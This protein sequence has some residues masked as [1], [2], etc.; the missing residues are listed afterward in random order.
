ML[1]E[2][3]D[4]LI[5]LRTMHD[6]ISVR[7][8]TIENYLRKATT[9]V[10]TTADPTPIHETR[11][12][13]TELGSSNIKPS[14]ILFNRKLPDAWIDVADAPIRSVDDAVL[15]ATAKANLRSWASEARRQSDA[16]DELAA[17]YHV[18]VYPVPWTT[19]APQSIRS[20]ESLVATSGIVE[21]L[22]M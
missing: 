3:T 5:D 11:R 12:F 7:S 22:Q 20:L 13:F 21:A 14:A 8:R 17:R 4:F 6:T 9:I 19:P 16:A 2:V 10:A 18:P 15:R 1:S